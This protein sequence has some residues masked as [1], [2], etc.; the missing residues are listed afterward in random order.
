MIL[1]MRASFRLARILPIVCLAIAFALFFYFGLHHYLTI[2][3][4]AENR[5]GLMVFVHD[6]MTGAVLIFILLYALATGLALP[7]ATILTIAGGFLFGMWLGTVW[8]V[9][10]ATCG[11]T[12]LF[13]VARTTF[14][15]ALRGRAGP[16][17]DKM[18]AGFAEN[19]FS[20]LLS[21][22]LIPLCPFFLV[23]MVPAFLGVSPRVFVLATAIGI[24]PGSFVFATVGA[25]LGSVFDMMMEPSLQGILTPQLIAALVGLA[26]LSLAPVLYKKLKA[27]RRN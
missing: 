6:H 19:A 22:R 8:V 11:A 10:A 20:Y 9:I 12:I 21:L 1:A 4:L 5:H 3:A 16:A 25:G 23:N 13:L 27:R 14:G 17:L 15:H 7:G 24:I 2:A 26:L 18:A